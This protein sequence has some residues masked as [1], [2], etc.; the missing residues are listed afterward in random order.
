MTPAKWFA[1]FFVLFIATPVVAFQATE[2]DEDET[3]ATTQDTRDEANRSGAV[4]EEETTG[5]AA[6]TSPGSS[7]SNQLS[8]MS[9]SEL[10]EIEV[11]VASARTESIIDTPAVVSRYNA[12]DMNAMGLRNLKDMLSFIP[13]VTVQD[14]ASGLTTVMVRGVF[15]LLNQKI[16]F[17]LDDVPYWQSAHSAIPLLGIPFEAIDH[18]EVIRGPGA[19][20]YGSNASA[21]VIKIVTRKTAPN[22]MAISGGSR[23]LV[24]GGGFFSRQLGEDVHFSFGFQVRDENGYPA[25]F[26]QSGAT[27]G[28]L[29]LTRFER[30]R[31]V[32]G[33]VSYKKLNVMAQA[34]GSEKNGVQLVAPIQQPNQQDFSGSLLH[35]DYRWNW[36]KADL[37]IYTDYNEFYLTW[38][39]DNFGFGLGGD[40][41]VIEFQDGGSD[42]YRWRSGAMLNYQAGDNVTFTGGAEFE[43]RA[44]GTETRFNKVTGEIVGGDI[45]LPQSRN[46]ASAFGQVDLNFDKW[47]FLVGG[48]FVSN[49]LFGEDFSPRGGIVYKISESHSLKA[50][51][52]EGFNSP[53]FIQT[54]ISVPPFA[55]GNPE[56]QP[57]KAKTVDL[58]YSYAG[59]G[60]LFVANVYLFKFENIILRPGA[61]YINGDEISGEGIELDYQHAF[62]SFKVF[63]G[64]DY[65]FKSSDVSER[66]QFSL[67]V[68]SASVS[69]GGFFNVTEKHLVGVSARYIGARNHP[70]G[71]NSEVDSFTLVNLNYQFTLSHFDIFA[72]LRNALDQRIV[73]PDVSF[74]TLDEVLAPG[75]DGVNFLV[76]LR[77]RF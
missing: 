75:G 76:G 66:D 6:Q 49:E 2:Q 34:Y 69:A 48:R 70:L 68:P 64:F 16:L 63:G 30:T 9:L 74:F 1:P 11:S 55:V 60:A 24:D 61:V 62:G 73:N 13:G 46:E 19:V 21:G 5:S 41:S 12:D 7:G 51:Y 31:S 58:A 38:H 59:D 42:N 52:S 39:H 40:D 77:A 28:T 67:V 50:L 45:L 47:R 43:R 10:L 22:R 37:A 17:L 57:E 32:L 20:F 72:T 25:L 23:S 26:E 15:D 8:S 27:P 14:S 18:V 44:T 35:A 54:D 3:S 71:N 33:Q 53:N 36:Q 4:D 56:L 29:E 65:R